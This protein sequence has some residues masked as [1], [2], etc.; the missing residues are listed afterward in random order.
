M[1]IIIYACFISI[2]LFALLAMFG[3]SLLLIPNFLGWQFDTGLQEIAEQRKK[4]K[5]KERL[6]KEQQ[7]SS[8]QSESQTSTPGPP[9]ATPGPTNSKPLPGSPAP[10]SSK[11]PPSTPVQSKPPSTPAPTL[12]MSA[13][14]SPS[15]GRFPPCI[16]FGKYEITTWYSSPY[17]Q[18]YARLVFQLDLT[19][20]IWS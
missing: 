7:D 11:P 9:P 5:E 16:E 15:Q 13:V 14:F 2:F 19:L 10:A 8:G 20:K 1:Y 17:P 3:V 6:E 4:E 18:E 12:S